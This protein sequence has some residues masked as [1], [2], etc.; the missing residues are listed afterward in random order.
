MPARFINSFVVRR[1]ALPTNTSQDIDERLVIQSKCS[2]SKLDPSNRAQRSQR[3]LLD[4]FNQ[5]SVFLYW[6]PET[7]C[8]VPNVH[9]WLTTSVEFVYLVTIKIWLA[10]LLT[11]IRL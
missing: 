3:S 6:I 8:N 5:M 9:C 4:D 1:T 10:Q 11:G 2:S 7:E